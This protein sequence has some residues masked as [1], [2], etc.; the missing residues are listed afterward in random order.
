MRLFSLAITAFALIALTISVSYADNT[1]SVQKG[2]NLYSISKRFNVSVEDIMEAN[3]LPSIALQI[4]QKL[5]IPSKNTVSR[6]NNSNQSPETAKG[7]KINIPEYHIVAKGDTLRKI[8]QQYNVGLS[9]LSNINNVD[10]TQLKIGQ[11]ILLKKIAQDK[12]SDNADSKGQT[13]KTQTHTVKKSETIWRIA[14]RYNMSVEE[15]KD[16]NNLSS[17][18]LK[19]GQR[20]SLIRPEFDDTEDPLRA[21]RSSYIGKKPFVASQAKIAEVN[22]MSRGDELANLDLQERIIL[23]A[24]KLLHLPYSFGGSSAFGIDCSAFVQKVYNAA[25]IKLPRSAREQY[26]FGELIDDKN[27]LARGDLVF[28]R[29]YASFPSHVGIYLGNN[30]FIHASTLSKKVTID[31]MDTPYY[32]KRYIGARRLLTEE[33]SKRLSTNE[34]RLLDN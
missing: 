24:K 6:P 21:I 32:V 26:K 19:N 1:Y 7:S 18:S 33:E 22:E 15:L 29:T 2:D 8:S 13:E 30:L 9:E 31:S 14:K 34:P 10:S 11:R 4:N 17:N 5:T 12:V 25:G 27:E 28:F 20:L 16:I 3:N 23:F